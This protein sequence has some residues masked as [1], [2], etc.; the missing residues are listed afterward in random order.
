MG[1]ITIAY[2]NAVGRR[3]VHMW[4][5]ILHPRAAM[6]AVGE[7]KIL[8]AA[9]AGANGV[10]RLLGGDSRFVGYR[11]VVSAAGCCWS[12]GERGG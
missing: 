5:R 2:A 4:T 6:A 10:G 8:A 3:A 1:V 11:L 12:L 9:A 7:P